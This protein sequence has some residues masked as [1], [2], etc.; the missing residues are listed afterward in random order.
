LSRHDLGIGTRD[1]DTSIEASL[2]VSL[3]NISAEDFA[4]A[5]TA[6]VWTLRTG[7]TV[8][9]PSVRPIGEI[10]ER[11]LLLETEPRLVNFVG[12]HELG[13]LGAVV[14]LIWSSIWVPTFGQDQNI[15]S[16][17]EWIWEDGDRSEVNIRV[18][19]RSLT[20]GGSIEI[21]FWEIFESEFT[22]FWDLEKSLIRVNG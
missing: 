2:V 15:W 20:G 22:R 5:H 4:G 12:V 16:T 10:E 17:T 6:V 7:E 19:A 18:F 3:N 9:W 1:L 8:G 21:P 11:V 14:E 13:T